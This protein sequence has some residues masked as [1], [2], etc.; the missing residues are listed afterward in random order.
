M[1]LHALLTC[2]NG[3]D[4][5]AHPTANDDEIMLFYSQ[6]L[7]HIVLKRSRTIHQLLSHIPDLI[8]KVGKVWVG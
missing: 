4:V 5:S 1:Y 7:M 8:E 2:F 3:G 6:A